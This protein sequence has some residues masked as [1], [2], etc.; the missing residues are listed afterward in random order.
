VIAMD[1][2]HV[3]PHLVVGIPTRNRKEA[4]LRAV[5]SVREQFLQPEFL[6]VAGE[7][8]D[9][10]RDLPETITPRRGGVPTPIYGLVNERTKGPAGAFNSILTHVLRLGLPPGATYV[11]FLDDDD[12]WVPGYLE[13]CLSKALEE[14]ADVVISGLI[15]HASREAPGRPQTV[16]PK[17]RVD[18]FLVSNPHLQNSNL[19]VR[20]S[21]LLEAGGFDEFLPSTLDRDLWI[22]LLELG[23]TR[24]AR[25]DEHLV[26]HWALGHDRLSTPGS[27]RKR[28]G[29][30][31]F[32]RKYAHRMTAGQQSLFN[33]RA[34][35]IF[36]VSLSESSEP[37]PPETLGQSLP[38]PQS[39]AADLV[40]GLTVTYPAAATRLIG[41]IARIFDRRSPNSPLRR[42]VVCDNS[43]ADSLLTEV[44]QPAVQADLPIRVVSKEE[45]DT[46]ASRGRLSGYYVDRERRKGI[47]FGRTALHTF[48]IEEAASFDSPVVWILDDD[49]RL[50]DIRFGN[51]GRIESREDL[52]RF[53]CGLRELGHSVVVGGTWGDPPLPAGALLRTQLLDLSESLR[54]LTTPGGTIP[55]SAPNDPATL[56]SF[57]EYYYDASFRHLGHL[58]LPFGFPAERGER[59]PTE[60][61]AEMLT[62]LPGI[63][64]GCELFRPATP[65]FSIPPTMGLPNRGGNTVVFDLAALAGCPNVS[66]RLGG[67]DARRGDTLWCI[68]SIALSESGSNPPKPPVGYFPWFVR[69]DRSVGRSRPLSILPVL[70]DLYGRSFTRAVSKAVGCAHSSS[71]KP[72]GELQPVPGEPL[73]RLVRSREELW[74]AF[75]DLRNRAAIQLQLNAWR[76]RGLVKTIRTQLA[77]RESWLPEA[78]VEVERHAEE[79]GSFLRAV[80]RAFDEEL[81]AAAL[82][83]LNEGG[84]HDFLRFIEVLPQLVSEYRE[85]QLRIIEGVKRRRDSLLIRA[86]FGAAGP[87]FLA[88]GREGR[89]Y[90]DGD[91][92]FKAFRADAADLSPD[93]LAF[94]MANL[95]RE[96]EESRLVPILGFSRAEGR[97]IIR[98]PFVDGERYSGGHLA[99]ILQLVRECRQRGLVLTNLHPDN[100]LVDSRGVRYVD[101]GRSIQPLSEPTFREMCKRAYLCYRWH[102]RPDLREILTRSL[103]DESLPELTGFREFLGAIDPQNIHDLMDRGLIESLSHLG[104]SSVLDFGC[105]NGG[106][107]AKLTAEGLRV[108][109]YDPDPQCVAKAKQ[110]LPGTRVLDREGI[111]SLRASGEKFDAV[112]CSLVLCTIASEEEVERV[113]LEVRELLAPCGHLVLVVCDPFS[114]GVRESTLSSKAGPEHDEYCRAYLVEKTVK[115]TGAARVDYHRPLAWYRGALHR[116]GFEVRD[117]METEG[118]D[119]LRLAPA[120]DARIILARAVRPLETRPEVSLL[121]R[122]CAMEWKTIGFQVRHIVSQLE[123]PRKF[124]EKIVVYDGREGPFARQYARGDLGALERAL[125][126]LVEERVIHRAI[127]VPMDPDSVGD[128]LLRWFGCRT[129]DLVSEGGQPI[130]AAVAGFDACSTPVVL[131]MDSDCLIGRSDRS[132]DF[133]GEMLE[134]F[135]RDGTALSVSMSVP[136]ARR[137]PF[138][139]ES[140]AGKWRTEVRCSLVHLGRLRTAL[141]IPNSTGPDGKLHFSWHRSLDL[142]I[143]RGG[144]N[145]Y[146]GGDPRTWFVHVPNERKS[147]VNEWYNIAKAIE[148]GR[149]H[150]GQIG[151]VDLTGS[152]GDWLGVRNE[153]LVLI[154]RGRNVPI[155]KIRRCVRSL[156]MQD[157]D[158]WGVILLDGASTNGMAEYLGEV[159]EHEWRHRATVYL[160]LSPAS[161][162]ENNFVAIRNLC[163][164]PESVIVT[165]DAD[166]QLIGA[167][168]LS[169][170]SEAYLHGADVTVGSMLRTDKSATYPVTFRDA[171]FTRGG[172]N[173]W[174]HLRTFRKSLFD[175]IREADLKIDGEWIPEA[176]DWA[177]MLPIIEMAEHP[178]NVSEKVYWYEP[179]PEKSLRSRESRETIV[180]NIVGRPSYRSAS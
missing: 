180:A 142:L 137:T 47:A 32:L 65:A 21:T 95:P 62:R 61:L 37:L 157:C 25:I 101:L 158:R 10:L 36:R 177:Y 28:L 31:R 138:T 89:I 131:Q 15:R 144:G 132:H 127:R 121:V 46:A 159:I 68:L 24:V 113:L 56:R 87:A 85:S 52:I 172:G 72:G 122:T 106:L 91:S 149:L 74:S 40:I 150:A 66:P 8:E 39:L 164:N 125:H 29:L 75:E 14:Q 19:F 98:M 57:P 111:A 5:A 120:S 107:S 60:V 51:T 119:I 118:V 67:V 3:P 49:V 81:V 27:P 79:I 42:I 170:V 108:T 147:K 100:L 151:R 169:M 97:L 126:D 64:E 53:L 12:T 80:E 48:L 6:V 16:P 45:I 92:A 93:Q 165:V 84:K 9:D 17:L 123:R 145:S 162:A 96:G 179:S 41:D 161:I 50:D 69:H 148:R 173:V 130:A 88:A 178:V 171:R 78:R 153:E 163:S 135:E 70:A 136:L 54:A 23:H 105:G 43:D 2:T 34:E 86:S 176:E 133:L 102:F 13:K 134:V 160:N 7:Q 141:P 11:A 59:S 38:E 55:L 35:E 33:R 152:L 166:D 73:E 22:R 58:E 168:A 63:L 115:Q 175:R 140:P 90:A 128:S 26:D 114:I 76:I 109:A 104:I 44:L 1:G 18:D 143:S 4:L 129:T 156:E 20:L 146:R 110:R 94:L 30:Q 124:L 174:Q 71:A 112:V 139:A 82:S 154:V 99:D 77:T 167:R 103:Y 155:S 83:N 116:A 117:S